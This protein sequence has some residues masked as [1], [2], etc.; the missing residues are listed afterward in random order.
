MR[1]W[2]PVFLFCLL[3]GCSFTVHINRDGC[4][5]CCN[6]VPRDP[7]LTAVK[8]FQ[9]KEFFDQYQEKLRWARFQSSSRDFPPELEPLLS[10]DA[11][12]AAGH[13]GAIRT[14]SLAPDTQEDAAAQRSFPLLPATR[15]LLIV[16]QG[17]AFGTRW[18]VQQTLSFWQRNISHSLD[19]CVR[20]AEISLTCSE[21]PAR[22][23]NAGRERT[24]GGRPSDVATRAA[25]SEPAQVPQAP[26]APQLPQAPQVQLPSAPF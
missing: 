15:Y 1:I 22:T 8:V 26:Q 9:L 23:A 24:G 7:G 17:T 3:T 11:A 16:T 13:R 21:R 19:M 6:E 2:L 25:M 4:L 5:P 14:I 18:V 20:G 12:D 10:P